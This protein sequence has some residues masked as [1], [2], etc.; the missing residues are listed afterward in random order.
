MKIA[1]LGS[2][3][4]IGTQSLD[5]IRSNG[6]LFE[7]ELL[8]ANSNWQLLARQAREFQPSAVV[9]A[10]ARY[11]EP[12]KEALADDMVKVYAGSD[13]LVQAVQSSEIDTV[14][15]AM[16]GFSGLAPTVAAIRSG[17]KIALA[18]KETLVVAGEMI[19]TLSREYGAPIVPVDSEHS[20]IFQ[21]LVGE[22]S[23]L[24]RVIITASGGA[25]R[26]LTYD[27]LY[28]V[29]PQQ[30]LRHPSWTMGAKITIDSATMVNK[31][32]EV[33]EAGW[34]FGLRPDQIEVV[35]HPE[36]I[37]H[38]FVEFEDRAIKAQMGNPDMRLPIQYALTFPRRLPMPY[39]DEYNPMEALTFRPVDARKYPCLSLAYNAMRAGGI[40]PCVMNAANEVAVEAFLKGRISYLRIAEIIDRALQETPNEK[41]TSIEHIFETNLAARNLAE[42]LVVTL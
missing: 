21:C 13:A 2:T 32:F 4:S 42:K 39:L 6:E 8:T 3:G 12:L 34:L 25:L 22:H 28:S 33:I 1:I 18:N 19:T 37:I 9:I 41:I 5:V 15:T 38:S 11:Y 7:V 29:T 35:I 26:D 40:M 36:S 30:A 27:E 14:I 17:K 24:R 16:V 23:P 10:D 20:A 31:G